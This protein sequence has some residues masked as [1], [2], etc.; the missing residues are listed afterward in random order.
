MGTHLHQRSQADRESQISFQTIKDASGAIQY[1][2]VPYE[3]FL[4]LGSRQE[5][6]VPNAVAEKVLIG[7]LTP[8]R[9]WREQL[10]LTQTEVAARMGIS[11]AAFAQIEAPEAKPRK[12]TLRRV[13]QALGIQLEQLDF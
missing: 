7:K 9:A 2:V 4:R 1:V 3:D 11:Q 13:A 12:S 10:G 6:G 5:H 8:I